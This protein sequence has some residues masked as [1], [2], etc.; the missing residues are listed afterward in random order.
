M[1]NSDDFTFIVKEDKLTFPR[2]HLYKGEIYTLYTK[3]QRGITNFMCH[4]KRVTQS[5]I[6]SIEDDILITFLEAKY[7]I[8]LRGYFYF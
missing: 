2:G 6:I 5:D 7:I 4:T 1:L 3:P 8:T